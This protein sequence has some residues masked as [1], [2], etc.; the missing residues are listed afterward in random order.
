MN[1]AL[2]LPALNGAA[3]VLL[4]VVVAAW[5][6]HRGRRVIA[7]LGLVASAGVAVTYFSQVRT[8]DIP[9]EWLT[10]LSYGSDE[11]NIAHLYAR[12]A[13][14]GAN[15]PLLVQFFAGTSR[16]TL[17]DV[18]RMNLGLALVNIVVFFSI[19]ARVQGL[20]W[21][22][23]WTLV[24]ALNP[25]TFMA[26]FS[27]LSSNLLQL[28]F[29]SGVIAWATL[30]DTEK[31]P[32]W[33][34]AAAV[35][36]VGLLTLLMGFTRPE[37]ALTGTVA[38]GLWAAHALLGEEAWTVWTGRAHRAVRGLLSVLSRHPALIALLC[39]AGWAISLEGGCGNNTIRW[40]ESGLYPFNPHFLLTFVMLPM[41]GLPVG[42]SVAALAG[43]AYAAFHFRR[44]GGIVL[45]L[46]VIVHMYL[47]SAVGFYEVFRYTSSFIGIVLLLGLFGRAGFDEIS[48]RRAWPESWRQLATIL[49]VMAWFTLPALGSL[50]PFL[51]PEY[52]RNGGFAQLLLDR[53]TQREVRFLV[54]QTEK[55]PDCVFVARA[56]QDHADPDYPPVWEY[57]FFGKPIPDHPIV[58]RDIE[59]GLDAIIAQHA[60]R[61]QCIRLYYGDDCNLTFTDRCRD[62]VAGRQVIDEERFWSQPYNDPRARGFG[63]PEIVLAT[64]QWR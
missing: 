9:T 21:A 16:V 36:L 18:V 25:A 39:L 23:P 32:R 63:A 3:V 35:L 53:N 6:R 45:S 33:V 2:D 64:Y 17:Y 38:L 28:Y 55:H 40:V 22:I 30:H 15:F 27:E 42:V 48:R 57:I 19:A 34:A 50:E 7:S 58:V 29:L 49:Y 62:F 11:M 46:I 59:M 52:G 43:A 31:Q 51:R 12:G 10:I 56:I 54:A 41:I 14:V 37:M 24:F 4:V 5:G 1:A 47:I 13:H 44:F 8:A 61:A 20:R 60:A 26:S